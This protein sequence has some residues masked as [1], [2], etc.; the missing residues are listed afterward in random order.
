MS[1]PQTRRD[2]TMMNWIR[3]SHDLDARKLMLFHAGCTPFAVKKFFDRN[4]RDLPYDV[5]D[6]LTYGPASI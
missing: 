5:Q 2:E 1:I 4:W 6:K 3:I